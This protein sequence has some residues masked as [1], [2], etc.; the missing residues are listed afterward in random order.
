MAGNDSIGNRAERLKGRV[1]SLTSSS[2]AFAYATQL[3]LIVRSM[4]T[5]IIRLVAPT[6][7]YRRRHGPTTSVSIFL[8]ELPPSAIHSLQ[9][10]YAPLS[11]HARDHCC[12]ADELT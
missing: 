12:V 10:M 9:A 11:G 8:L 4:C 7:A 6:Q 3:A 1:G 2:L 5:A